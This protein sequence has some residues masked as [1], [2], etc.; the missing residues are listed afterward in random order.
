[1]RLLVL[2]PLIACRRRPLFTLSPLQL[3][4]RV[5]PQRRLLPRLIVQSCFEPT[6]VSPIQ[7]NLCVAR[8]RKLNTMQSSSHN[9][10][11]G[12][13]PRGPTSKEEN[14]SV[15][16][17]QFLPKTS[18][19]QYLQERRVVRQILPTAVAKG[20]PPRILHCNLN[21]AL[22]HANISWPAYARKALGAS[23]N[24]PQAVCLCER[25]QAMA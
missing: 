24:I 4:L 8:S 21:I 17:Q 5:L 9:R 16:L 15:T 1:M 13:A 22:S 11:P 6:S 23:L 7:P 18:D 20:K 25:K 19:S 3:V 12:H 10:P 2:D 14:G